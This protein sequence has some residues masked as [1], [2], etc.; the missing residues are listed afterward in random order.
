V[1]STQQVRRIAAKREQAF[2]LI[3]GKHELFVYLIKH[4]TVKKYAEMEVGHHTFITLALVGCVQS[5]S[6]P[7]H[8]CLT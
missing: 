8:V 4:Q 5:A 3:R 1:D 2:P 7:R 6:C